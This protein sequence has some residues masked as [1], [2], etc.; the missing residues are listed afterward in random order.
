MK[1]CQTSQLIVKFEEI[2][3]LKVPTR[4]QHR[5][6]MGNY[7]WVATLWRVLLSTQHNLYLNH[8]YHRNDC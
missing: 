4:F 7:Q 1:V 2:A 6:F 5:Y 3:F 8:K